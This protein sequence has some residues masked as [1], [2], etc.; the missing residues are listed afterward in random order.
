MINKKNITVYGVFF[1]IKL[2]IFLILYFALSKMSIITS[3]IINMII[4]IIVLFLAA[5]VLNF[6]ERANIKTCLFHAIILTVLVFTMGLATGKLITQNN[7][8]RFANK[9]NDTH[10]DWLDQ[11]AKQ[12]MIEKG[13]IEEGEEIYSE[14]YVGK[15]YNDIQEPNGELYSEWDVQ[16]VEQTPLG[17]ITEVFINFTV[18]FFS[19]LISIKIFDLKR[20]KNNNVHNPSY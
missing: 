13:L 2:L 1:L 5:F 20:K 7:K 3:L 19:G 9:N 14:T 4:P 15:D 11:Q 17:K 6:S 12:I 18:A 8:D 10:L 16:M